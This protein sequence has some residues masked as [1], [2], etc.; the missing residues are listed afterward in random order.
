M[1]ETVTH[2]VHGLIL[3]SEDGRRPGGWSPA[4]GVAFRP[5]GLMPAQNAT[6][7]PPFAVPMRLWSDII[8]PSTAPNTE[9]L[10][11]VR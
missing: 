11:V 5:P 1:H 4:G 6:R 2:R 8:T 9:T 3:R 7:T 10:L